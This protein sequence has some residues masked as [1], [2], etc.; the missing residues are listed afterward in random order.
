MTT[1]YVYILTNATMP[2]VVKIGRTC[3]NVE[4]RASELW[5]TGVP[6][7]FHIHARQRTADCVQLEADMH[8]EFAHARVARNREFFWVDPDVAAE[9]LAFLALNQARAFVALHFDCAVAVCNQHIVDEQH[10]SNLADEFGVTAW[11]ISEAMSRLTGAEIG[12]A[13]CA[14]K[15]EIEAELSRVMADLGLDGDEVSE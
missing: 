9:R 7:A 8:R 14:V 2:G 10:I 4:A 5:Q 1:G 12:A 13:V 15:G 3:R 11:L 6:T